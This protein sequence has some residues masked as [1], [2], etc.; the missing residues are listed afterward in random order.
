METLQQKRL[1]SIVRQIEGRCHHFNGVM[2]ECCGAG[3]NY[4]ALA[5][6]EFGMALVLPC[7]AEKTFETKRRE[8][9]NETIRQCPKLDRTTHEQA[10]QEAQEIIAHS[11]RMAKVMGAAHGH[12]K[13][14]KLG[15]GHG[16]R[17]ELPCPTGCGGT[18]H[19]S[20]AG[21]NGHMHAKCDTKD[22]VSWM[23]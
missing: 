17:G 22:C 4:R 16:G 12:A 8:E 18:L 10:V 14:A 20:V 1:D 13:A 5:G 2:N 21:Y 3:V 7:L 19:Y 9:M 6:I 11:D 23:E 15:K